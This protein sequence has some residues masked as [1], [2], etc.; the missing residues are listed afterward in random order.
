MGRL[1]RLFFNTP[2]VAR[3]VVAAFVVTSITAALLF[4]TGAYAAVFHFTGI[5]TPPKWVVESFQPAS[6]TGTAAPAG[7]TGA[8]QA[9]AGAHLP[10]SYDIAGLSGTVRYVATSGNDSGN[11][12]A[13]SPYATLAKAYSTA[14]SGDT[15][16]VRG[17]TYRQ[18]NVSI[19][20]NK[21]VRIVAYPGETP[22]FNGATQASDGWSSE[23]SLQSRAY[24]AMPVTSGSGINFPGGQNLTGA[25][26]GKFPDQA[27]VG[28]TQLKQV[29]GKGAV[30]NGTFA[31]EGG[32]LYMTASD[33]AKGNVEVSNLRNFM[34]IQAPGT[35]L[36]GIK[37]TRYSNSAG[38]YGVIKLNGS[39]D[40][41]LLKNVDISD[42]S[43]IAV[44]ISG[45]SDTNNG[46]T[47]KNVTISSSNWMGVNPTYTDNLTFDSVDI[48]GM[49]QWGEFSY[50]PQSGAIKTSRTQHTKVLNSRITDNKS[51]GLW[52]D[53]SNYDVQVAN[54]VITGNLGSSVFFEISDNLTLANNYIVS[55]AGGDKAVKL[56]GSS[57]LKL[58]NNTII[59]GSDPVGIYTDSRSK[60][61]CADA[62]QPLCAN[63]YGSDRDSVHPHQATMDWV[64]RLDMMVNNIIAYPKGAGYCGVATAVCITQKNGG[65]TIPLSTIIH[66]ADAS[67]PKTIIAGNVYANG[68]GTVIATSSGKYATPAA[69]SAAMV[70]A[71]NI[72]GFEAG[73]WSGSTYIEND[74]T[75]TAALTA[76]NDQATAIPTDATINQY[77]TAGTKHYGVTFK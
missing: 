68:S 39:A 58:I 54:N 13:S 27:W 21:P 56:A 74:G 2:R 30:S 20:T 19:A 38:D 66:Q 34:S 44:T 53:Q 62:S 63:S 67:R 11:G 50:S 17:G 37:V 22:V 57:G 10:I 23:G 25:G 45:G 28:D 7:S 64:P 60:P 18:G 52:F 4:S 35:T 51:H 15:I 40:K 32:R 69:F 71:V 5:G 8:G 29:Q 6:S 65:A 14:A 33:V 24:T 16:V 75:P 31:V 3:V 48:H 42:T 47:F 49:N 55:P 61:G 77:L 36:E 70:S 12:T 72:S 43:F 59:G 9:A 41:T 76:L 46:T 73:A 26:D 1:Q